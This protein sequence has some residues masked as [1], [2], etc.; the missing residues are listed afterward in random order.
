MKSNSTMLGNS[1]FKPFTSREVDE[2]ARE[3]S[4]HAPSD[5]S[6][7]QREYEATLP[8]SNVQT[9]GKPF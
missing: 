9:G 6:P 3:D 4:L 5:V 7:Q 2:L 1:E 8:E